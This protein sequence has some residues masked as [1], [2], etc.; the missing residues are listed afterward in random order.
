MMHQMPESLSASR[1]RP[2]S[3]SSLLCALC[4]ITAGCG[5]E[6]TKNFKTDDRYIRAP[7]ESSSTVEI[8]D[9][10][11]LPAAVGNRWQMALKDSEGNAGKEEIVVTHHETIG[12]V[13]GASLAFRQVG[14]NGKL[15]TYR[16]EV[17]ASNKTAISIL[18]SGTA[19]N[20]M[21][22]VPP[23]PLIA[24]PVEEGK[25][26]EWSGL[27]RFKGQMSP[28]T[29]LSRVSGRDIISTPAGKFATYRV[30][31]VV[32]TSQ[33]GRPVSFPTVRWIAPG[34]GVVKQKIFIGQTLIVKTLTKY[35][36]SSTKRV[37]NLDKGQ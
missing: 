28:S 6:H 27:L 35:T 19:D 18:S 4:L 37:S 7:G 15:T 8:K 30:D 21:V 36:V 31:T 24:L 34:V 1:K 20:K 33:E 11:L 9:G 29:A 13:R 12:G 25:A 5:V 17:Y 22:M 3:A 23:I 10:P 14:G 16:E 2:G 26:V 32:T